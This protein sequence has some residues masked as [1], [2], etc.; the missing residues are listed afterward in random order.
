MTNRIKMTAAERKEWRKQHHDFCIRTGHSL[1]VSQV[2]LVAR[3]I[4]PEGTLTDH[5]KPL[6]FSARELEIVRHLLWQTDEMANRVTN[7]LAVEAMTRM[8]ATFTDL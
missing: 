4:F 5:E 7:G 3:I 6:K 8:G 2:E 1:P